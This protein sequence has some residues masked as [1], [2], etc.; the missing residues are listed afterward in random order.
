M[1][2]DPRSARSEV[3]RRLLETHERSSS[4]GQPGPWPRDVILTIDAKNFP[5]AFGSDG[6]EELASLCHAIEELR[7]AGACRVVYEPSRVARADLLPH[8]V[9]VGPCEIAAAYAIGTPDG[10]EPLSAA[11][12]RVRRQIGELEPAPMAAWFRDYLR[13]VDEALASADPGVLG[14]RRERFKRD[15]ID[16]AD[17][18]AAAAAISAGVDAWERMLSERIFA[19]SKRLSGIRSVVEKLLLRSDPGWVG[20]ELDEGADVLEAYGV[21]RKPGTLRCAGA[22]A[23]RVNGR[24]YELADFAPTASLPE[25]WGGAWCEAAAT[26]GV[27]C[28]TTVENE[29]PFLS[30]VEE[31]GGAAG[32]AD[33]RELVVYVAGFPAP[34]LTALLAEVKRRTGAR[35]RHWGDADVGG[36][37]IWR[38]LRTRVDAPIELFRTTEAW[39]REQA[40]HGGQALTARERAAL[41]GLHED[42]SARPEPDF[43]QATALVR[44]LLDAGIKL[45][46]ERY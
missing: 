42:F 16:V 28:V 5:S 31:M 35:L 30:Y 3:I 46:Q 10:F 26:S 32:L 27:A 37:L 21:R 6:R 29:F 14:M 34:W 12:E 11:I 22:G 7:G 38:L 45:E 18:L 39:V 19:R 20:F 25:A 41:H 23:L 43:A 44:A 8:Q 4:F 24:T 1:T 15:A 33:R 2:S 9:R 17:A 40:A 13:R 36:L